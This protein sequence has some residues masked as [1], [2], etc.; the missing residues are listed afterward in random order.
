MRT[1]LW[2]QIENEFFHVFFLSYGRRYMEQN[3]INSFW[4]VVHVLGEET[5]ML[6]ERKKRILIN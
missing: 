2:T 3:A 1:F 6:R 5:M 4:C